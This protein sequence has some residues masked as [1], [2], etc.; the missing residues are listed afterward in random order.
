M[1][2][3]H[4]PGVHSLQSL[5]RTWDH[6]EGFQKTFYLSGVLKYQGDIMSEQ[7]DMQYGKGG[8]IFLFAEM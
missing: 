4:S 5:A 7:M 1:C 3:G 6:N 2:P 8:H